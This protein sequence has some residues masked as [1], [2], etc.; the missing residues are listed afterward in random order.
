MMTSRNMLTALLPHGVYIV[1]SWLISSS[2]IVDLVSLYFIYYFHF[3]FVLF[4]YFSIFRT[5]RVRVRS[6]LSHCHNQSQSDGVVTTLVM[7]L[8]RTK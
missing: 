3:H 8:R 6:D 4:S 1:H 2:Q 7:R 5:A